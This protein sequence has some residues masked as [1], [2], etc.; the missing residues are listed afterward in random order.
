MFIRQRKQWQFRHPEGLKASGKLRHV[1]PRRTWRLLMSCIAQFLCA[2]LLVLILSSPTAAAENDLQKLLR[3]YQEADAAGKYSAALEYAQR[4]RAIAVSRGGNNTIF[5]AIGDDMIAR[6]YS[7]QGNYAKSEALSKQAIAIFEKAKGPNSPDVAEMLTNLAVVYHHQGKYSDALAVELR[8]LNIYE[9]SNAKNKDFSI[10]LILNNLGNTYVRL[11]REREAEDSFMRGLAMQSGIAAVRRDRYDPDTSLETRETVPGRNDKNTARLLNNLAVLYLNQERLGDA[12]VLLNRALPIEERYSGAN[13]PDTGN[14]LHNLG[15]I[16]LSR[17][18]YEK[19]GQYYQRVL[20]IREKAFGP[21]SAPVAPSL[22]TMGGNLIEM[23]KL[24]EAESLLRRAVA[25]DDRQYGIDSVLSV[26]SIVYLGDIERER[27]NYDSAEAHFAH[28]LAILEKT[29]GSEYFGRAPLYDKLSEIQVLRGDPAGAL[30][31]SRKA[32]VLVNK[33]E[34]V[35]LNSDTARILARDIGNLAAIAAAQPARTAALGAEAFEVAQQAQ[36]SA[37]GTAIHQMEQRFAVGD[38]VLAGLMREDQDLAIEHRS[39]DEAL[40]DL[41]SKTESQRDLAQIG[42]QR[43]RIADIDQRRTAITK[44]LSDSFPAFA[45]LTSSRPLT[46]AE[47]QAALQPNEAVVYWLVGEKES[48]VFALTQAG[49]T[50]KTIAAGSDEIAAKVTAFRKGLDVSSVEAGDKGGTAGLFDL[51]RAFE[52]Y[53]LL[54]GPVEDLVRNQQSLMVVPSGVLTSLPVHLLVTE[55]PKKLPSSAGDFAPYREAA[56]LLRRHAVSILPSVSSLHALRMT[57][58]NVSSAKTMVAFGDPV[59]GSET[60]GGDQ[61]GVKTMTRSYT[62]FWKGAGIDRDKLAQAL[63]RLADT[64]DELTAIAAKLN[65]PASDLHLRADASETT[66]KRLPLADYR[67]VYFATHGLVAGDVKGLAE[68]SLALT[69]PKQP[70]STDDGLLTA[71]EVA[72]LKLNAEWVVLS[73]CNTIAGDKPGAE[74]L[75][76]LAR[77]FLYAGARALLV[78]HWAVESASATRLTTAT[79]DILRSD[80]KAGRAGALQRAMLAYLDD[81]AAPTNAYP[82]FWGPFVVIG[83]GS[84][85]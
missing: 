57:G 12:E 18:E 1:A 49:M 14:V 43:K 52:L 60:G 39:R 81:L 15:N 79:F 54:M 84:A 35:Q 70:S 85:R 33:K 3:E 28:A 44:Q 80:P 50:W 23:H 51:N 9:K 42:Q 38:G 22:H 46:V 31:L 73:A 69:I 76:G 27:K 66:V 34:I 75:S 41:L 74:A 7:T 71:S 82:A 48:Y 55:A 6:I 32:S 59:F 13:H 77:S 62:D 17:R 26:A 24:D 30:E 11:G 19:A 40:L 5:S 16:W 37:A 78:T 72:Q 8:T 29:Y 53:S 20:T 21:E 65:V 2:A 56:W 47:T 45:D 67:I 63:P 58:G 61:R 83:E 36:H 10:L 25:I 64:S 4:W 68:P